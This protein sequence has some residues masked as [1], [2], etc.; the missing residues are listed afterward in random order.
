MKLNELITLYRAQSMD[1]QQ[2]TGSASDVFCDDELLT[3]YANEGQDEACR[4]GQLLRD[5]LGA[6]CTVAFEGGAEAVA[7][8]ARVITVLRAHID[9]QPV[10]VLDVEQMDGAMPGWQYGTAT[11][12]PTYL[13]S[14]LTTGTLHLWPRP[15]E[16]GTLKLTVQRLPIKPMKAEADKPE[17][18][19]EL[20]AGLVDWMLYRA[21]SREDTDLHNDGKAAVALGRFEAEFGRKASG[22]NEEWVRRG[23]GALPGPIA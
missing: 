7:L 4:R 5:S 19:P 2:T 22:R 8:D 14:G 16:A 20:H 11:G 18:R 21:Y 17:I 9:G 1:Q 6:M 12:Q 23:G 10:G 13:V 3:I 15:A